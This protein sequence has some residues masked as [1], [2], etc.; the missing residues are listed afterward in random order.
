L[1]IGS[2][3]RSIALVLVGA[4]TSTVGY[5]AGRGGPEIRE[6]VLAED[7]FQRL[8]RQLARLEESLRAE[9]WPS[10][11][12]PAV[13]ERPAAEPRRTEELDSA[14][15]SLLK[16]IAR[17]LEELAAGRPEPI[18]AERP[19][20]T[21]KPEVLAKVLES[22]GFEDRRLFERHF[23]WTPS[24]IYATYGM[25]D[26]VGRDAASRTLWSYRID[27]AKGWILFSFVDGMIADVR[28]PKR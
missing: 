7:Q 23:C 11:A 9:P 14:T 2:L 6:V 1:E 21:K 20:I 17:G 28:V 26:S 13:V 5:V 18:A 16:E 4:A 24:Q 3:T 10:A 27:G 22:D 15:V 12:A 19:G 25:P 8:T